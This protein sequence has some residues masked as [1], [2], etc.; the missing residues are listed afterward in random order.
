[1]KNK[2]NLLGQKLHRIFLSQYRTEALSE[3]LSSF[4]IGQEFCHGLDVGCG[5]G[6]IS[7]RLMAMKPWLKIIGAE[8]NPR[9]GTL[10]SIIKFDGN[11][12]PFADKSFDFVLLLDVLH[13]E[14]DFRNLLTECVRVADK[15]IL[16]KDHLAENFWD[17]ARLSIMDWLGNY[18]YHVPLTYNY[19]SQQTWRE[20]FRRVGSN[21][22]E[23]MVDLKI[24]PRMTTILFNK[25]IHF[26]SKLNV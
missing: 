24:Y 15:F 18:F 23:I 11:K 22:F 20:L 7:H 25:N 21:N 10:I 3:Y 6:E 26:I 19:L 17:K 8:I 2:V 14:Q 4:L 16:I 12:L 5:S 13:H 9:P 1:M